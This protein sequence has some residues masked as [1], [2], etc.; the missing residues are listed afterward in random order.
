MIEPFNARN[1]PVC[2][3]PVSRPDFHLALK[4]LAW[5]RA[6]LEPE[7][8]Y[9]LVVFPAFSVKPAEVET[10]GVAIHGRPGAVLIQNPR[11]YEKP[12]FGYGAAANMMLKGAL[13]MMET[14]YPG[15]PMLWCEADTV[16]MR[17]G[18]FFEIADEYETA[19]KPFLGD[20]HAAG[21][22]SHLTGNAVY[23]A[24]WRKLC[25]SL[26]K[27]PLPNPAQ[28][29]D[30]MC[31]HEIVPLSHRSCRIQQIFQPPAFI[32][33]FM[34]MIHPE[35]SLFH[36]CKDGTLVDYLARKRGIPPI[37]LEP[38]VC[39][40]TS[41]VISAPTRARA[42][43]AQRM[44]I[45]IVTFSRDREFLLYCLKSIA[46][47]SR[48]FGSVTV[49][50]PAHEIGMFRSLPKAV[51]LVPM[52]EE[53]GKGHL[54]HLVAKCNADVFCPDAD[55][56]LHVDADC[57]FW[58]SFGPEDYLPKGKPLLVR[59]AYDQLLN[60]N[61]KYWR[62]TVKRATGL[63]PAYE[64]MVRHPQ[65][66]L[67]EVYA[68]TRQLVK[69]YTGRDFADYVLSCENAFPQGFAEFPTLGAVALQEFA[70][71]Y[72]VEDY[73]RTR[74]ALELRQDP[75]GQWQYIYRKGRDK[76]MET[77]SH[78]GISAYRSILER[79]MVGNGPDFW[80]K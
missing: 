33:K 57:M 51:H 50:V 4:W 63:L 28:G 38:A 68:R 70:D 40:P 29:W 47:Y 77:W 19:G 27:L 74:D 58:D 48:N 80:V 60:P 16:A 64:T 22:W 26:A 65:V 35:T 5:T 34:A 61:R 11:D 39:A 72:T 20:F 1:L 56:I 55:L 46:S 25:P 37:P 21:E 66:H 45:L 23:P 44:D 41:V 67:R 54:S 17:P 75:V 43:A 15:R 62:E 7:E 79:N 59:E 36:R 3:L 12:E 73:D 30:T 6:I 14:S 52:K 71:R 18:W 53:P 78:A 42:G 2:V 32:D 31:A 49:V 24:D 76:L 9:D 69:D 8:V 13:E 10:L